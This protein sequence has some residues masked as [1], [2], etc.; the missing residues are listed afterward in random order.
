MLEA[1]FAVP[2]KKW[3]HEIHTEFLG[4]GGNRFGVHY[5]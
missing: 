1:K 2:L 5:L 3:K 4:N